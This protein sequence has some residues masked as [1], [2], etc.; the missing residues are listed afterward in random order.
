MAGIT[1]L[2]AE[3][4][5]IFSRQLFV[6]ALAGVDTWPVDLHAVFLYLPA[7]AVIV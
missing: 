4:E 6:Y 3:I 5:F 7:L 1:Q 2:Q